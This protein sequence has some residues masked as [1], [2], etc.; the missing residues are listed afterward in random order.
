MKTKILLSFLFWGLISQSQT[1]STVYPNLKQ[2]MGVSVSGGNLYVSDTG[3]N[4]LIKF[5]IGTYG[6]STPFIDIELNNPYGIVAKGNTIYIADKNN[7]IIKKFQEPN[8]LTPLGYGFLSSPKAVTVDNSGNVYVIDGNSVIRMTGAGGNITTIISGLSSPECITIDL[9]S[10]F[11]YV[12]CGDGTVKKA[13]L[14]GTGLTT[15]ASGLNNPAGIGVDVSGNTYVAE[16]FGGSVKKITAT[17]VVSTYATGLQGPFALSADETSTGTIY[18]TEVYANQVKRIE[19]NGTV[20]TIKR[21]NQPIGIT[22]IPFG[23]LF[24]TDATSNKLKKITADAVSITETNSHLLNSAFGLTYRSSTNSILVADTF[25]NRI[26]EYNIATNTNGSQWIN[27]G[28]L[29][30]PKGVATDNQYIYVANTNNSNILK[31]NGNILVSELGNSGD[32]N[33]PEG[34]TVDNSG[35]IFIADTGHQ[36]IK[37]M[38]TNGTNLT[39]IATGFISPSGVI[40]DASGK[41][42]VADYGNNF[43]N[44]KIVVLNS[45]GAILA[46]I[47][48]G[49]VKP[50]SLTFDPNGDVL[51]SDIGDS[52]FKKLDTAF[53]TVSEY[54]NE[55]NVKIFPNPT[56]DFVEISSTKKIKKLTLFDETGKQLLKEENPENK[57]SVAQHPKGLYVMNL[58]FE[59]DKT[60][61]KK[62]LKK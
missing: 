55:S 49:L 4:S 30:N 61:T 28:S 1:I 47:T 50:Y 32:F 51:I 56:T 22:C 17:G 21:Y 36:A 52:K 6:S 42:Y 7:G 33:V 27:G 16:Y 12:T 46:T 14:N 3:N 39:T 34:I 31:Y 24:F 20:T 2:P 54:S 11:L 29:N 40:V 8:S 43:N 59:N 10:T 41:I 44:G 57:I 26:S 48:T 19:A 15:F 60:I 35:N 25:N 38:T 37:K 45:T 18:V 62:I 13:N 5:N 9:S 53:L 58:V 23:S